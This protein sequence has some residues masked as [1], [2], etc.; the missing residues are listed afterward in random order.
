V[1]TGREAW[2]AAARVLAIPATP[3][4]RTRPEPSRAR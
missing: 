2:V 3:D 4:V 1:E